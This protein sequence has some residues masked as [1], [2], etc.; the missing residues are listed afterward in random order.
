MVSKRGVHTHLA[1]L[2]KRIEQNMI[3]LHQLITRTYFDHTEA[4]HR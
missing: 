2:L 3:D 1:R 4:R